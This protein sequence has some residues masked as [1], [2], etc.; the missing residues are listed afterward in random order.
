MNDGTDYLTAAVAFAAVGTSVFLFPALLTVVVVAVTVGFFGYRWWARRHRPWAPETDQDAPPG[1]RTVRA[2][3]GEIG[4]QLGTNVPLGE[5][6]GQSRSGE[7]DHG[8]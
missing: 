6:S 8:A 5:N 2:A 7:S 3:G 1:H 4:P